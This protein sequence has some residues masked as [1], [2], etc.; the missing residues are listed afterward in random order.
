[1]VLAVC[2]APVAMLE[3]ITAAPETLPPLGSATQPAI[4][5]VE[6]VFCAGAEGEPI[7]K[8]RR[9]TKHF[10][11]S[12]RHRRGFASEVNYADKLHN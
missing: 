3:A 7:K 8:K 6:I 10:F 12:G 9:T 1:M 11:I 5:P 4:S 2:V